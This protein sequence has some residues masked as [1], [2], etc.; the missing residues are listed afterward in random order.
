[1][2]NASNAQTLRHS[3]MQ[4]LGSETEQ[5][6]SKS[7]LLRHRSSLSLRSVIT[8]TSRRSKRA[9]AKTKLHVSEA[10]VIATEDG[11]QLPV[12]ENTLE[13]SREMQHKTGVPPRNLALRSESLPYESNVPHSRYH[14]SDLDT[15]RTSS[16]Q[17]IASSPIPIPISA[18]RTQTPPPVLHFE[19]DHMA[20]MSP[21]AFDGMVSND[22]CAMVASEERGLPV[23][24]EPIDSS[25]MPS[26]PFENCTYVPQRASD[27]HWKLRKS[28]NARSPNASNM[29]LCELP[30]LGSPMPGTTFT[31]GSPLDTD[32]PAVRNTTD[33]I[34]HS[35]GITSPDCGFLQTS[36]AYTVGHLHWP[37]R[38]PEQM[39][40]S[41][42]YDVQ[43]SR[44][45]GESAASPS[46]E[47][48]DHVSVRAGSV[49]ESSPIVE[50]PQH[51]DQDVSMLSEADR[52]LEILQDV[53]ANGV[54]VSN[55]NMSGLS[56][57]PEHTELSIIDEDCVGARKPSTIDL[58]S[59]EGDRARMG[60]PE[61]FRQV[62]MDRDNRYRAIFDSSDR[63]N[64]KEWNGNPPHKD[65]SLSATCEGEDASN[66]KDFHQCDDQGACPDDLGHITSSQIYA[67]G[68]G[69]ASRRMASHGQTPL[70]EHVRHVLISD[71]DTSSDDGDDTAVTSR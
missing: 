47:L 10:S 65:D 8:T 17:V 16:D 9:S 50:S 59:I 6:H 19:I 44:M 51:Q 53:T 39:Q 30:P 63:T 70:A 14:Q 38:E 11:R 58:E 54:S 29:S 55:V 68:V 69:S 42:S 22:V 26:S 46:V 31:L 2:S 34:E 48:A 3:S 23:P 52:Y 1:M 28:S 45:P 21:T 12:D 18:Q 32:F 36:Q 33:N 25:T 27:D 71:T 40:E 66:V 13:Q 57:L 60:S 64:D 43:P 62:R 67:A 49:N 4:P 20:L 35:V 37:E 5:H 61:M 41:M 24:P 7:Y 15:P 56:V